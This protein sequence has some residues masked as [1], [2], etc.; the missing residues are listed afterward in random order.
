MA[1]PKTICLLVHSVDTKQGGGRLAEGFISHMRAE[2]FNIHALTTLPQGVNAEDAVLSTNPI[3]LI[4]NAS[5]IRR[6]MAK[7]DLVHAMDVFPYGIVAA[8]LNIGLRKPLIIGVIGSASLQPLYRPI[9][10]A[11]SR[12]A[13][14]QA[15]LLT[16]TSF[17]MARQVHKKM[18]ELK[19]EVIFPAID[20][21]YFAERTSSYQL[22]NKRP[23]VLSVAKVKPRKGLDVSLPAFAQV[24]AKIPE[25]DY[26]IVGSCD[27]EYCREIHQLVKTLGI[28][29]RVIFKQKISD[30]E[31]IALY[32]GASLFLLLPQN[33]GNDVEGF[34]LV[35]VEAA[36]FG[37]PVIG[38]R[39]SGA[40]DA[41]V[42]TENGYLV[43]PH[44]VDGA[45]TRM[46]QILEDPALRERF[47]ERSVEFAKEDDWGVIIKKHR[48]LY[49]TLLK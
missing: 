5:K 31:L 7:A 25:L 16:A 10:A 38:A 30:E 13:Y 49:D 26:V 47:A 42:D 28:E 24:A 22:E 35:F 40:E 41:L 18:P 48:A 46:L 12:W 34:G 17:Y 27:G 37:L 14:R 15:D 4:R 33:V 36:A 3:T 11:L 44:D 45:A 32:R 23:F 21:R 9:L 39:E 19:M 1:T 6:A 8:V 20:Y 29:S 2:G 43:D